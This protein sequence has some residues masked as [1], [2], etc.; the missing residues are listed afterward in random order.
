MPQMVTVTRPRTDVGIGIIVWPI[1][2]RVR[3]ELDFRGSDF[4]QDA[5]VAGAATS[6]RFGHVISLMSGLRPVGVTV[7]TRAGAYS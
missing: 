1:S 4:Q 6:E 2:G 7:A 5:I 3:R